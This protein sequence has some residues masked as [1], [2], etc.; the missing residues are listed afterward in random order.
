[1]TTETVFLRPDDP[2]ITLTTYI[3]GDEPELGMPP[4]PAMVVFPGGGYHFLSDREAEPIAKVFFAAGFNVFIL[5]YSIGADA[6]FPRPL[7]DASRAI[8]H[9]RQ[10]AE[11]YRVDPSRVFIIGFS[12]GGHLAASLGTMWHE[13]FARA[14]DDMPEGL[15][16]P[17]GMILAYAVISGGRCSH[18]GSFLR[19]L[20]T[21]T[22]TE[23]QLDSVSV[24]KHVSGKTVPAF[25]WHTFNDQTVPVENALLMAQAMTEY[26]IPYELHIFP[27]GP[28]GMA[29]AN[30]Q[31]VAGKPAYADPAVAHWVPEAIE[32]TRR[33][34]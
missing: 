11:R 31:T 19:V 1:M 3:S 22:P 23:E 32:W 29:L 18:R 14:S 13:P 21:D 24:E 27:N 9:V 2:K 10:N 33:V 28:H 26:K 34:Q 8:V 16:R 5:R 25:I 15:N 30:D 6:R 17:T 20:G 4:R 7:V 12:A